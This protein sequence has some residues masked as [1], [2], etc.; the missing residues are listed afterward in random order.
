[1]A[2]QF[3]VE[4]AGVRRAGGRLSAVADELGAVDLTGPLAAASSALPGSG[5]AGAAGQVSGELSGV[6]DRVAAAVSAMSATAAAAAG[7]YTGAD[8]FHTSVFTSGLTG[9]TRAG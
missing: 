2:G 6:L 9:L 4:P 1:M 7:N 5:T 3:R 8:A